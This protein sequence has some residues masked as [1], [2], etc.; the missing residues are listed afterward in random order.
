MCI[1]IIRDVVKSIEFDPTPR[2]SDLLIL[3]G[4]PEWQTSPWQHSPK[5]QAQNW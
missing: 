2:D 1:R 5:D 4:D 3:L